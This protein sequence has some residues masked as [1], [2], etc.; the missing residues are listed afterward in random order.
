MM[1]L[2]RTAQ[3]L[4]TIVLVLGPFVAL[5]FLTAEKMGMLLMMLIAASICSFGIVPIV[6]ATVWIF[7][8]AAIWNDCL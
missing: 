5:S 1:F 8:L 3:I 6:I 2:L 4:A 7:A